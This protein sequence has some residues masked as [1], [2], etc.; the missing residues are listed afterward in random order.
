MA[1]PTQKIF[2]VG[3][4]AARIYALNSSGTPAAVNA[5]VYDGLNVGG[6]TSF[7]LN[8][9]TPT[10]IAH[11]GNNSVLQYD[12]LPSLDTSNGTLTVSRQDNAT[13]A[14]LTG[15]KVFDDGERNVIGWMTS[16]QST[17]PTV[18]LLVYD[19]AKD[20]SGN[21][22]WHTY[23]MPRTVI[24]PAPKSMSR[25]RSDLSFAVQPSICTAFPN[26]IAFTAA[27]QGYTTA[28]ML[29]YQS[30]HRI[31]IAAWVTTATEAAY[32]LPASA[33][34]YVTGGTGMVVT[35][36]GVLM[37]YGATADTTHYTANT[38]TITFGGALTN[39]DRVVAIYE[40]DDTAVMID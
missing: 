8:I 25:E 3:L 33:P 28:Q 20:N 19:Q 22:V 40:V 37:T 30:N 34:A 7:T 36:N 2:T 1:N 26:G 11:P 13:I 10:T 16:A 17:E 29:D 9:P 23:I 15:T 6:P 27:D 31:H 38:T 35:K 32:S 5:T 39:A 12:I 18:M 24:Y 21:R 14:L 4:N